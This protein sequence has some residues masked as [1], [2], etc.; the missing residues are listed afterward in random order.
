MGVSALSG[1]TTI[2]VNWTARGS[3]QSASVYTLSGLASNLVQSIND[4][5]V[6]AS[7]YSVT[8]TKG[9]AI[10]CVSNGAG[11]SMNYG[12]G[13][14]FYITPLSQHAATNGMSAVFSVNFSAQSLPITTGIPSFVAQCIATYR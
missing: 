7:T 5:S 12:A 1:N 13:T 10:I 8:E 14:N 2:T 3:T 6:S 9:S 4:T 11:T